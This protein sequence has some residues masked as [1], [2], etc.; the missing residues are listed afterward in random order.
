[1]KA[2]ILSIVLILSFVMSFV[3]AAPSQA[4]L[5]KKQTQIKN[6]IQQVEKKL[7]DSKAKLQTARNKAEVQRSNVRNSRSTLALAKSRLE[8]AE[9]DLITAQQELDNINQIYNSAKVKVKER[10]Y[11]MYVRGEQT[12][13]DFFASSDNFAELLEK[14]QVSTYIKAQDE[15]MLADLNEKRKLMEE[16]EKNVATKKKEVAIWKNQV[17]IT[18]NSNLSKQYAAETTLKKAAAEKELT[19]SKYRELVQESSNIE[20]MLRGR[21]STVTGSNA[22]GNWPVQARISSEF[23]YR[24]HPI[25]KSRRLHTGTD[26]AAPSGTPIKATG[27]GVVI[28]AGWRGGYGNTVMIDHGGNKVTLYAHMSSVSVKSGQ[29]VSKGTVIG[30]VGSTGNSTGPHCHYEVRINGKPVNPRGYV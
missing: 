26:L 21:K 12:Y 13:V 3:L 20:S 24:I 11:A 4:E 8:Q 14:V 28:H 9:S 7:K 22:I 30:K 6:N 19:E 2:K 15:S 29:Q 23:G 27:A 16:K 25:S 5:K 17:S 10:I 1:M 18:H